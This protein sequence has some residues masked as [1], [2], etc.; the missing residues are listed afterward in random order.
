M[1]D[2]FVCS[3]FCSNWSETQLS[4]AALLTAA[5][6]ISG[7][8]FLQTTSSCDAKTGTS[9]S[10]T[11]SSK[12]GTGTSNTATGSS[13]PG[14]STSNTAT[15]TSK[16][17]TGTSLTTDVGAE[18]LPAPPMRLLPDLFV[19]RLT[20]SISSRLSEAQNAAQAKPTLQL[21]YSLCWLQSLCA[22]RVRSNDLSTLIGM[23]LFFFNFRFK[24]KKNGVLNGKNRI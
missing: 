21:L 4:V 23:G 20:A 22:A 10:A 16:P 18:M 14:T 3:K 7:T 13:K 17:G 6:E 15:G 5:T 9:T 24:R 2:I 12:P 19:V 1:F 11:G 8:T